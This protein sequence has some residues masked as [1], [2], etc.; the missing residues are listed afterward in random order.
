VEEKDGKDFNGTLRSFVM[1][2][3]VAAQGF[4]RV[5]HE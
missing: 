5:V 2:S 3:D 1:G 4:T